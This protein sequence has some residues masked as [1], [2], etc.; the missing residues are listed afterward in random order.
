[1][2][3]FIRIAFRN[4]IQNVKKTMIFGVTLTISCVF[5]LVSLSIGNGMA[6]QILGQYR[7]FQSG[8]VT[9]VWKNVKEY[10]VSDPSRLFFSQYKLDNDAENRMSIERLDDFIESHGDEITEYYKSLKG[11][12]LIDTGSYASYSIIVGLDRREADFLIR[13]G[14]LRLQQGGLPFDYKFGVCISD[15]AAR[16]SDITPGDWVVIDSDTAAGFVNSLEYRVT[17]I[18]E[19]N[20]EYDSIYVYMSD[21]DFHELFDQPPAYF[22]SVRLYLDEQEKA[23]ILAQELDNYLLQWSDVLRAESIDF[24]GEFYLVIARY[25]KILFIVFIV[26]MLLIIAVGIR[27]A[28]RMNLFDR[29]REFGTL[30]AI[31]F[32]RSDS[33]LI[34]F[35]EIFILALIFFVL[36][37]GITGIVLHL[38]KQ[39]GLYIGKGAIA[40]ILGGEFIYPRF[41]LS[42][43]LIGFLLIM[44]FSLF[45]PLKPGLQLCYQNITRLLAQDQK[46]VSVMAELMRQLFRKGIRIDRSYHS[47]RKDRR[48]HSVRKDRS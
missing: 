40:Y 17:G 7:S 41:M 46:R 4:I 42:D 14:V 12:G 9:V 34:I 27:S 15:E 33:F 11:N 48:F 43:T 39:G 23:D 18:Y 6:Q 1:M 13:N 26:F 38:L 44:S 20:S 16:L 28:V 37:L 22:H 47:V 10:D 25:L 30:R 5:L 35:L 45:A 31:G 29:M 3:V 32:K 24:S 19:S 2:S 36:S 8:D 21:A